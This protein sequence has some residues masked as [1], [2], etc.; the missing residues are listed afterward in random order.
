MTERKK[1]NSEIGNINKENTKIGISMTPPI[2]P[3]N[4]I[5]LKTYLL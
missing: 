4:Y 2:D 3:I 5:M 1:L